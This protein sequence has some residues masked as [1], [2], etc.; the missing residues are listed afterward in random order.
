MPRQRKEN[1]PISIRMDKELYDKLVRFCGKSG[2]P[3]TTAIERA[4]AE[5]IDKYEEAYFLKPAASDYAEAAEEAASVAVP[6]SIP[7]LQPVR[8]PETPGTIT[9][10]PAAVAD[11]KKNVNMGVGK[12]KKTKEAGKAKKKDK[13]DPKKGKKKSNSK[14]K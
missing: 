6:V 11:E 10:A 3:K 12:G 14:K 4:V 2:Q 9:R 13:Q 7:A 8:K 1:Q 5:Y